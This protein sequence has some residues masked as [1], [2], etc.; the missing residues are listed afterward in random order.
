MRR[1]VSFVLALLPLAPVALAGCGAFAPKSEGEKLWRRLCSEC[2]GL[3]G[4]GNTPRYMGNPN[5]D[6]RDGHWKFGGDRYSVETVVRDGIFG[7]MPANESLTAAEMTQL[8]DY[9][10]ELRGERG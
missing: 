6:L 10:Y 4:A 1:R 7:L 9:L 8:L 5:A 3:D 2:H